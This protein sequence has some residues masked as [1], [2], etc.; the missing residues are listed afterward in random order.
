VLV[1]G[2]SGFIGTHLVAQLPGC[3]GFDLR[4]NPFSDIR[5][6]EA[7]DAF[8]KE[9]Q[10]DT[11]VHLAANPN[12]GIAYSS[13]DW[14]ANSNVVGTINVLRAS[15]KH[16]VKSFI[17]ASTAHVYQMDPSQ[18]PQNE[19]TS[20]EPVTPYSIS[21]Y[22]GELY[23]RYFKT[24][25]LGLTILRFF[26]VYGPG[27]AHNYAVPDLVTRI[28]GSVNH[29]GLV[30]VLGPPDDSRDF[31]FVEDVAGAIEKTTHSSPSGEVI[32][33]G[34]GIETPTKRLC[35]SI[36][37]ALDQ[38][39]SFQ[40]AER[41]PGRVAAR[42]QADIRKAKSVIGWEPRFDLA[43]GLSRTVNLM[44]PTPRTKVILESA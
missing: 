37:S 3:V 6:F 34:S 16:G 31:V 17:Y 33:V 12:P 1:T 14:D 18:I 9:T 4:D 28:S 11:V 7:I 15:L 20:C 38:D 10:P 5:N 26:N 29:D 35:E 23:C 36:A 24:K 19:T 41:P 42:F 39:V 8:W 2:S 30:T 40:Y 13:P 21:K 22:A 32:N 25:G 44:K 27:Q 43:E